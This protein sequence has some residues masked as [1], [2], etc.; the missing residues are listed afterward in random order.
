M[1]RVKKSS[2]LNPRFEKGMNIVN[3]RWTG[4]IV[5]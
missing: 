5:H 4:L 2:S 1:I 3:K